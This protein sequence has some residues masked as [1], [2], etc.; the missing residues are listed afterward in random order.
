MTPRPARFKPS[1]TAASSGHPADFPGVGRPSAAKCL[2]PREPQPRLDRD[3][4]ITRFWI[5]LR[6]DPLDGPGSRE[7]EGPRRDLGFGRI[8]ASEIEVPNMSVNVV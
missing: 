8:V 5:G 7:A 4:S 1:A 3:L 6:E 2:A